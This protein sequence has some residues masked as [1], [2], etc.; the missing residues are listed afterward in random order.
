MVLTFEAI[1]RLKTPHG[2]YTGNTFKGLTGSD[3]SQMPAGWVKALIGKEIPDE[4]YAKLLANKDVGRKNLGHQKEQIS[5]EIFFKRLKRLGFNSYEEYT[6]SAAWAAT[7]DRF[8]ELHPTKVCFCCGIDGANTVH[9]K[10]YVNLG[11]ET[12]QDLVLV[13]R[14]CHYHIH[15]AIKAGKTRLKGAHRFI[16]AMKSCGPTK[17]PII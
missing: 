6:N 14:A 8:I 9:H 11:F 7:R 4:L 16:R 15:A 10:N 1:A 17:M 12:D 5:K 3:S 13:C 2:G